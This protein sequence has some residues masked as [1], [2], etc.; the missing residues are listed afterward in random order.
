VS[1]PA[2]L[3]RVVTELLRDRAIARQATIDVDARL[4]AVE[5]HALLAC[6]PATVRR[7]A[8]IES[9]ASVVVV[10]AGDSHVE[11]GETPVLVTRPFDVERAP[12]GTVFSHAAAVCFVQMPGQTMR[13][14]VDGNQEARAI[15]QATLLARA[16]PTHA[17]ATGEVTHAPSR[18]QHADNVRTM[19]RAFADGV[20]QKAIAARTTRVGVVDA[21]ATL[22]LHK[23]HALEPTTTAFLVDDD[24]GTWV[25][26]SPEWLYRKQG[27]D[28]LVDVL[29]GTVARGDTEAQDHE[30]ARV[31]VGSERLA[32]ENRVVWDELVS[33]LTPL[34]AV[35]HT[36]DPPHVKKLRRIQHLHRRLRGT[37]HAADASLLEL[38]HPTSAV[39][40]FPRRAAL[41]LIRATEPFSRGLYAGVVGVVDGAHEHMAVALRCAHV[42]AAAVTLYAGGGLVAGAEP[43]VEWAELD[44]K[45]S[46][47]LSVLSV[48]S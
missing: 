39:C 36:D 22:L 30:L 47:W 24:A 13:L 32:R 15:L 8:M 35:L 37:L 12:V 27:R 11:N 19:L 21:S 7:F 10:A 38:L 34:C 4:T 17:R 2:P 31:L 18:A 29:A 41:E 40:G 14:V 28:I 26:A 3:L 44:A 23:L 6:L 46:T 1:L 43:D 33:V 48:L 20:A 25:G 16:S 42:T 5:A 45:I 9:D